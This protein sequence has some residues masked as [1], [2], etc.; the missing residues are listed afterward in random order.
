MGYRVRRLETDVD[1]I[2]QVLDADGKVVETF[3]YG[4]VGSSMTVAQMKAEIKALMNQSSPKST[5]VSETVL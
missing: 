3:T 4:K 5:F 1:T 2:F